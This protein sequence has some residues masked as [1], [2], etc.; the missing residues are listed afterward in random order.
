MHYA[1]LLDNLGMGKLLLKEGLPDLAAQSSMGAPVGI[2]LK[3]GRA[4]FVQLCVP[5]RTV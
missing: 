2:A 1:V 3:Y 5:I 4:S